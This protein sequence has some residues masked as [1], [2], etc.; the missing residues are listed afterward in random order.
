MVMQ[1]CREREEVVT[2]PTIMA[3]AVEMGR[4][5]KEV[6]GHGSWSA[7]TMVCT[8]NMRTSIASGVTAGSLAPPGRRTRLP[9][10]CAR[11]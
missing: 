5:A 6:G 1:A 7:R 11:A 4:P 3:A 2:T 8:T 10:L 9:P